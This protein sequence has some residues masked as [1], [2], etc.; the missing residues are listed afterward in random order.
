MIEAQQVVA[1]NL[2]QQ[3]RLNLLHKIHP[4]LSLDPTPQ[5]EESCPNDI[6]YT[7]FHKH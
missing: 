4:A 1:H 2:Q 7:Y 3:L 5:T 6:D